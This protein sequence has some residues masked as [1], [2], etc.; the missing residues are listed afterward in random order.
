MYFNQNRKSKSSEKCSLYNKLTTFCTITAGVLI[1]NTY[2]V[3]K[4]SSY[5]N[6][7]LLFNSIQF[8]KSSRQQKLDKIR[9]KSI[10]C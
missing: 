2:D 10:I 5:S 6:P 8:K 1:L 7:L 4:L 3:H 9:N